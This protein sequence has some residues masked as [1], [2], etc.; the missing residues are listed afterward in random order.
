M[1]W[2]LCLTATG[3]LGGCQLWGGSGGDAAG[4][5]PAEPGVGRAMPTESQTERLEE[6]N[7][8]KDAG[9]YQAAM[10][11]F[12]EILAENPTVTTAYI[13]IGDIYMA[14]D[15]Y[16]NAEPAYARAARLE[17]RNF[18]AQYGHGLALQMLERFVEAIRAYQR[19]LVIEPLS[20]EANLNMALSYMEIGEARSAL[21]FA[22]QAV[23]SDPEHG[24]AWVN[25]GAVYEQL[26]M[27]PEAIETY[28]TAMELID[29]PSPELIMNLVNVLARAGR[30]QET[31][32]AARTLNRIEP[33]AN[34]WE[35][36]G[37]AHFRLKQYEQSAEAY[38]KAVELDPDHWPSWNGVGVNALNAWLLSKKRDKQARAEAA[39]ALRRSL[40]INGDQQKTIALISTYRQ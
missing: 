34:A 16:A 22:Q 27:Y 33:S 24:P 2:G 38:R 6:A 32:D 5:N 12:R 8:L 15:D 4:A 10:A 17:P 13:G 1:A 39:E 23:E 30:Y 21:T 19:A 25:L 35:R 29:P 9:D 36:I 7:T 18:D 11:T 31:I 26:G 28:R 14:Q 20:P 40:R 37:W 3:L